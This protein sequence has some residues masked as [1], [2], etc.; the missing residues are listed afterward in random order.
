MGGPDHPAGPP[1]GR[2]LRLPAGREADALHQ[3]RPRGD[4]PGVF[5]LAAGGGSA[6]TA[7]GARPGPA[8]PNPD[9]A[10]RPSFD[11]ARLALHPGRVLP[12]EGLI[13]DL[14]SE[15]LS[16][17]TG[18]GAPIGTF[19]LLPWE[20]EQAAASSRAE[21]AKPRVAGPVLA[22]RRPGR[23]LPEQRSFFW[24]QPGCCLEQAACDAV[25]LWVEEEDEQ[26]PVLLFSALRLAS[27]IKQQVQRHFMHHLPG[28]EQRL[29]QL[30][31]KA[32]SEDGR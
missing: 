8:R 27:G 23:F 26:R 25:A 30:V 2:D 22:A 6:R 29:L 10:R 31:T 18:R 19:S 16:E 20:Q 15:E 12:G 3:Q 7:A 5:N 14:P 28:V 4:L 21:R 13:P 1:Q 32:R 9:P 24:W 11:P 17:A